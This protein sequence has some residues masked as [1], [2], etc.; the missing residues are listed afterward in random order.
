M[1]TLDRAR[2]IANVDLSEIVALTTPVGVLVAQPAQDLD[3][4]QRAVFLQHP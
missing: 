3:T 1:D 4:R 2:G